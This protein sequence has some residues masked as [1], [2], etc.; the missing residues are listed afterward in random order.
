MGYPVIEA[1]FGKEGVFFAS[2]FNVPVYFVVNSFAVMII[3]RGEQKGGSLSFRKVINPPMVALAAG[4]LMFVLSVKL[5]SALDAAV[6]M[7]G[8]STTPLSLILSGLLLA[9]ADFRSIFTNL[10][11]FVTCAIRLLAMPAVMLLV[12]TAFHAGRLELGIPVIIAGMPVA[13]NVS[14]LSEKYGGNSLLGAQCVFLSTL[15]SIITIPLVIAF[16]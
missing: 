4:F 15:L 12:M 9:N 3:S 1:V 13:A 14:I 6:T 5:P 2:I 10:K 11:V 16:L 7:I 8:A